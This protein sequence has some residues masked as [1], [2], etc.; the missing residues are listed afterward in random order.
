MIKQKAF[1]VAEFN[2]TMP[3]LNSDKYQY[4]FN[5]RDKKGINTCGIGFP[6]SLFGIS[7]SDGELGIDFSF[8]EKPTCAWYFPVETISQSEKAYELNY[9]ASCVAFLWEVDLKKNF[10]RSFDM[11]LI[12]NTENKKANA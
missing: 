11:N 5:Q 8:S 10:E 9:Q 7:D 4:H 6:G 2:L 1:L 3:Q 12:F